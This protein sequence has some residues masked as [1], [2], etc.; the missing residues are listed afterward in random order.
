VAALVGPTVLGALDPRVPVWAA[1]RP[2]DPAMIDPWGSEFR[3][4]Q[5]GTFRQAYSC[6]PNRVDEGGGGD[7]VLVFYGRDT[8]V[9]FYR[10][11]AEVLFTLAVGLA[12]CWE[13]L[14]FGLQRLRGPRLGIG[15]ELG[16]AL[17][18]AVPPT[19][20]GVVVVAGGASLLGLTDSLRALGDTL[21][22]PLKVALPATLYLGTVA[23]L[24]AFRL[25]G[26]GD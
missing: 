14:R 19:L 9:L 23:A 20:V 5:D 3:L 25:R 1:F 24:L 2:E 16:Q 10:I 22:V 4:R 6:G 26:S 11:G 7:D 12:T 17:A 15:A 13:V 21:V 18:L 8:R